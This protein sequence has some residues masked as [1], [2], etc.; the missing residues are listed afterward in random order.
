MKRLIFAFLLLVSASH[1]QTAAQIKA[2][3]NALNPDNTTGQITPATTRASYAAVIDGVGSP[4]FL[5][6]GPVSTSSNIQ[7]GGFFI[8]DG[9]LITNIGVTSTIPNPIT[10]NVSSSLVS[11]TTYT[12]NGSALTVSPTGYQSQ[13]TLGA[14]VLSQYLSNGYGA[15]SGG[16]ANNALAVSLTIAAAQ[17][18]GTYGAPLNFSPKGGNIYMAPINSSVSQSTTPTMAFS[19]TLMSINGN[20]AMLDFSSQISGTYIQVNQTTTGGGTQ[21]GQGQHSIRNFGVIGSGRTVSTTAFFLNSS[22]GSG[23][24]RLSAYDI[25]IKNVGVGVR[26]GNHAYLQ[27]L[28][29]INQ[30]NVGICFYEPSGSSDYGENIR[31]NDGSCFNGGLGIFKNNVNGDTHVNGLSLD[32]MD[33]V[34]ENSAGALFW[35]NGHIEQ[36]CTNFTEP[37]V[38]VASG[39]F[40]SIEISDAYISCT[41]TFPYT[42]TSSFFEVGSAATLT[43][44]GNR[45]HH[46]G[47]S[48]TG[49][50][51]PPTLVSGTG[52]VVMI[53][54]NFAGTGS[55]GLP[56]MVCNI[57]STA[58]G[59]IFADGGFQQALDVS[60]TSPGGIKD[61]VWISATDVTSGSTSLVSS[62]WLQIAV[63]GTVSGTSSGGVSSSL[64][65]AVT[66]V[67][68]TS[69][70]GF[71]VAGRVTPGRIYGGAFWY[72][73]P[74]ALSQDWTVEGYFLQVTGFG[75]NGYPIIGQTKAINSS[76]QNFIG[77][78]SPL[79]GWFPVNQSYHDGHFGPAN[80]GTKAP[81]WA[82]YFGY[83][84]GVNNNGRAG[85]VLYFDNFIM[86]PW[87]WN[88]R[89]V[90][91]NR[92]AWN[93]YGQAGYA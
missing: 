61:L 17:V 93:N 18:G 58:C 68:S 60:N 11:A 7:T 84:F 4:Q 83:F 75:A 66:K 78:G 82:N 64:G 22:A 56:D 46:I 2:Q 30:E 28:N 27:S 47:F 44:K 57:S 59:N 43:L 25:R 12:G 70:T 77:A 73:N 62:T 69:N 41:G 15:L 86:E 81:G 37:P 8:G 31:I 63:S 90:P 32:Y 39:Q 3:V 65:L 45:M 79:K 20:N 16:T 55:N 76:P 21:Y 72:N 91:L 48:P 40:N 13:T 36:D 33:K 74:N 10:S 89:G 52:N 34:I 51:Y 67:S 80:S 54:N 29:N 24:D 1:A 87:S 42:L 5:L 6:Q 49:L 26:F 38:K 35:N 88:L 23:S 85:N 71:W 50:A 92:Y 19:P 14:Y 53:G 9:S